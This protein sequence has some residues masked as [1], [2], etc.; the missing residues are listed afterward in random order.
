[1]FGSRFDS[2]IPAWIFPNFPRWRNLF[3]DV[4]MGQLPP[5]FVPVVCQGAAV[6][7][8]RQAK[9]MPPASICC[10]SSGES[11]EPNALVAVVLLLTQGAGWMHHNMC[12]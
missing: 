3:L 12:G 8:R 7:A 2:A 9:N 11:K 1:M 6:D 4:Q 10:L 5:C